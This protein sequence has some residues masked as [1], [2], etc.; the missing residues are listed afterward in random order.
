MDHGALEGAQGH[1]VE[2]G[3]DLVAEAEHGSLVGLE[4][5]DALS[6]LLHERH[7]LLPLHIP[8]RSLQATAA[9]SI[10]IVTHVLV[11]LLDEGLLAEG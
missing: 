6:L 10:L 1:S 11:Y 3:S 4:S 8:H 5:H 9:P 2:E 7:N